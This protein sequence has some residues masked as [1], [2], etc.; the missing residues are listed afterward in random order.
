MEL[1]LDFVCKVVGESSDVFEFRV[2]EAMG[3]GVEECDDDGL[4]DGLGHGQGIDSLFDR[5]TGDSGETAILIR[6]FSRRVEAIAAIAAGA[7]GSVGESHQREFMF[8]GGRALSQSSTDS[9]DG[10]IVLDVSGMSSMQKTE[11]M[12]IRVADFSETS[13]VV[14]LFS[15]DFGKIAAM[16]KGGRRL[17]GPFEAALDLLTTCQ[18]VFLRKSTDVLDLL[19]EAKLITRFRPPGR[20][21]YSLY[22][23][24]YVAEL[25]SGL[26]EDYDPYPVLYD[27][28]NLALQR[29]A[30][31][32]DVRPVLLRFEMVF[33]REIGQMPSVDRCVSCGTEVTG[34][35]QST[36]T[37][38]PRQFAFWVSSG[39]LIC[40]DC[41]RPEFN[42]PTITSETAALLTQ[43]ADPEVAIPDLPTDRYPELRKVAT[44][45]ICHVLERRPKM[46][47]FLPF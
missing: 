43:F 17:K 36:Q 39:G 42:S 12:V 11:A 15:R 18:I 44:P 28:A 40:S 22:A 20:N 3:A 41:R 27:Q 14:T 25:L 30:E 32:V 7:V 35:P 31:D 29:L 5:P 19:T 47:R 16:A 23:G 8:W 26:T 4:A 45:A 6:E 33:L 34:D 38:P 2:V 46:F 21:L 24:Y 9:R 1:N 37:S 10:P 13:R